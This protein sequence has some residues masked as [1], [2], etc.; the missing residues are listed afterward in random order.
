MR[1]LVRSQVVAQAPAAEVWAYLTDWP[2][3]GEWIP[4]T[5]VERTS[6][7][8]AREVGGRIR[9][10]TGVGPLGFWDPMT[11]TAWQEHADGSGRCEVLHLG[12]VVRGDG[13][14]TVTALDERTCRVLWWERV[15]VPGGRLGALAWR[16]LG[17]GLQ[18]GVDTAL[19]R[20]AREVTSGRGRQ[21][22]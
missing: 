16:L 7:G 9:A 8:P 1:A 18:R 4:L 20:L 5:R 11:I 2:R 19:N 13:G 14:F 12:R 10:W 6:P 3:Q 17:R 21:H 22:G 15:D